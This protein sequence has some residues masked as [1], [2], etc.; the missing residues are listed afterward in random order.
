MEEVVLLRGE[1]L[2]SLPEKARRVLPALSLKEF[3]YSVIPLGNRRKIR[4][5]VQLR[6][7]F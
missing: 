2:V 5:D 7:G 6:L 1:E 4:G 3:R